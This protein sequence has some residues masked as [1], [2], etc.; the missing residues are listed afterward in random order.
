MILLRVSSVHVILKQLFKTHRRGVKND[1]IRMPE[2]LLIFV[3]FFNGN[4]N[5]SSARIID[6]YCNDNAACAIMRITYNISL[7]DSYTV[8][9]YMARYGRLWVWQYIK[10]YYENARGE[11]NENQLSADVV[12]PRAQHN[13]M[14]YALFV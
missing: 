7:Y 13:I 12:I 9:A 2:A 14:M 6:H 3:V 5:R 1:T 8:R 4:N 10:I 11:D